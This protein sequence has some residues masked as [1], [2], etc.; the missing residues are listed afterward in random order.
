MNFQKTSNHYEN[1][2]KIRKNHNQTSTKKNWK[3]CFKVSHVNKRFCSLTEV[4]SHLKFSL[5]GTQRYIWTKNDSEPKP[6]LANKNS[7]ARSFLANLCLG[8]RYEQNLYSLHFN[9]VQEK[10]IFLVHHWLSLHFLFRRNIFRSTSC[11][12][13][14]KITTTFL[15]RPIWLQKSRKCV[16]RSWKNIAGRIPE[17]TRS[18]NPL[19][20]HPT[21]LKT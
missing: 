1:Q 13:V 3:N 7:F 11:F 19:K 18:G 12:G 6:L 4:F 21:I 8:N 10:N 14:T 20:R 2:P 9:F 5:S 16:N 15:F 17:A